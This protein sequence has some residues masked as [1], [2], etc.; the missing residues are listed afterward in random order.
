[1]T[2][3]ES[4]RAIEINEM[5]VILPHIEELRERYPKEVLEEMGKL[6][7]NSFRSSTA[8]PI[9]KEL[10]KEILKKNRLSV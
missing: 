6:K 5:Y 10:L 9:S 1:M 7:T 4:Q 8:K 2:A 3:E